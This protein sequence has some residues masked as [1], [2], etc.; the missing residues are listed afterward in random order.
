MLVCFLVYKN[1]LDTF[2]RGTINVCI[3]HK[4][5]RTQYN[6]FN[7]LSWI[8][9]ILEM[10]DMLWR[11]WEE[12]LHQLLTD[13]FKT[14]AKTDDSNIKHFTNDFLYKK[15]RLVFFITLNRVLQQRKKRERNKTRWHR[16]FHID[17]Q[18]TIICHV[19]YDVS[20]EQLMPSTLKPIVLLG[21]QTQ[22]D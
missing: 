1:R 22:N 14:S 7:V 15:N 13:C 20:Y 3:N 5:N 10:H 11:Y 16:E 21:V 2:C 4:L 8:H 12:K 18:D 9:L 17:Y 6:L 19:C